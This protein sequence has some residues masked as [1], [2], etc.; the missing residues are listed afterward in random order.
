MTMDGMTGSAK[1]RYEIERRIAAVRR[2]KVERMRRHGLENLGPRELRAAIKYAEE[3]PRHPGRGPARKVREYGPCVICGDPEGYKPR[4]CRTPTR[5]DLRRFGIEGEGC[6]KCSE[7]LT[8]KV[9]RARPVPLPVPACILP[10]VACGIR[11]G[12]CYT[13][14]LKPA[15]LAGEPFGLGGEVCL[16]CWHRLNYRR[17]HPGCTPRFDGAGHTGRAS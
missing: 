9:R 12:L 4:L 17:K 16:K 2:E 10:C 7:R 15:R 3:K 8:A 6:R 14:S 5:V 13:R 11:G 1:E